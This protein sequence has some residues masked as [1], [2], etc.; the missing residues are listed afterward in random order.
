MCKS[1]VVR[2]WSADGNAGLC[3]ELSWRTVSRE[4]RVVLRRQ[5]GPQAQRPHC[6]GR[7][8]L[9]GH[10]LSLDPSPPHHLR[11]EAADSETLTPADF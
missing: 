1:P 7:L 6:L 2:S 10:C 3:A 9:V 11:E 4:K 8:L 5:D